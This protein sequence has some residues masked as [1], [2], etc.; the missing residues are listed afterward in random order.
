M[1]EQPETMT[2]E[3][4]LPDRDASLEDVQ[5]VI[6]RLFYQAGMIWERLEH[7]GLISGNGHH[8]A[9]EL[10]RQQVALLMERWTKPQA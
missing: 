5:E 9:Q 10:Q 2:V 6:E 7:R 4:D 8:M 3:V 1:S